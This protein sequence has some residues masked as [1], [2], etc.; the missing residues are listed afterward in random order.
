MSAA[1]LKE[2][3]YSAAERFGDEV[4]IREYLDRKFVDTGFVQFRQRADALGVW[5]QEQFPQGVHAALIG[6]TTADYLTAWFGIQSA[7]SVSVPLDNAN[8]AER[9]ADEICRSDSEI[10]FFDER[11]QADLPVFRELCPNVK[12]YIALHG[13]CEDALSLPDILAQYAGKIPQGMPKPSDLAAILFTSGTTG[14]SKGVMLLQSNLTDNAT[15]EPD[16]GFHGNK[17]LTVLP[18]HHVFCFTCDILCSMWYGRMLCV[19]DSLMRVVKNLKLF[20]PTDATFVPMISASILARMEQMAAK[21]PDRI[22]I[23]KEIF[24]ENF[25]IIYSGGAYLSPKIID[26]YRSFGIEIAQGYGMTEV[27]PRICNGIANCPY[28]ESVGRVVPGCQVRIQDSEIQVKSPSVMQGYYK[29]PEETAAAVTEDG[30]LRT[31]DLGY[32]NDDGYVF[33]TG[34]RKILRQ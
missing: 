3:M 21:N 32:V 22:A 16:L 10:L 25:H 19:N 11:H 31:G 33:I 20:Q 8:S 29:N 15:C 34:R 12:Y 17:R 24:G 1:T 23:G 2:L 5:V 14:K 27:A 18:I 26:G 28:P 4:F 30:W 13:G 9:I 7:C 6:A